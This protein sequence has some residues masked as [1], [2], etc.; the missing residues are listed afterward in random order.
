[1][2]HLGVCSILLNVRGCLENMLICSIGSNNG[3]PCFIN[4]GKRNTSSKVVC[5]MMT[6]ILL[7][8]LSSLGGVIPALLIRSRW[9]LVLGAGIPWFG[10]LGVLLYYEYFVPY[11]GGGA[12]MWPVA[13]FFGGVIAAGVGCVS[14]RIVRNIRWGHEAEG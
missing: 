9:S 8:V 1:V 10:L 14:A 5:N 2:E 3:G 13:Q 4:S 12:S 6:W 7:V 11:R